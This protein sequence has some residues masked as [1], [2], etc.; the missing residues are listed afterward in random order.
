MVVGIVRKD[1]MPIY[2]VS[3][4]MDG[5]VLTQSGENE[6]RFEIE[7]PDIALLPGEYT[8]KGHAMDP[9]GYRLFD[10]LSGDIVVSGESRELGTYRMP[11]RWCI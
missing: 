7:Y 3:S 8:V 9:E 11:H 10:E 6:F 4:E 1:G 2:G 5:H